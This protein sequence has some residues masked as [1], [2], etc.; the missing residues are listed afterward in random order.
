MTATCSHLLPEKGFVV[1]SQ[2][3]KKNV[4]KWMD[5]WIILMCHK[6]GNIKKKEVRI[7][8]LKCRV[9]SL[10]L[11]YLHPSTITSS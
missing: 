2:R 5:A 6:H 9:D 4:Y 8:L 7:F 10:Q 1:L 3:N 11:E